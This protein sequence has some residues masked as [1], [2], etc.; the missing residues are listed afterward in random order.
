MSGTVAITGASGFV[1]RYLTTALQESGW[2]VK[3]LSRATTDY[4][5]DSLT[6]ALAGVDCVI[7]L[8]GRRMTREDA[9]ND[10]APFIDPNVLLTGRLM[11]A[12][13]ACG[14]TRF[15]FASTIAVYSPNDPTPYHEDTEP[16]PINA[17]ALSKV[18]AEDYLT[19]L[20]RTGGPS[21]IA[22]RLAAIYG[23]GEKGTPALMRFINQACA[24]ET[25]TLN[26]NANYGIDQLYVRD[27]VSAFI[28]A[29]APS[30]PPGAYNIGAGQ[31]YGIKTLAQ[32]VN[33]VFGNTDNLDAST[34][35]DGPHSTPYMT[36]TKAQTGLHWQPRF[37]LTAGLTDLRRTKEAD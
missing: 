15:V 37:D 36:I 30:T 18:M 20:K 9:P 4:S 23:H 24:G 7:H 1:G 28:A 27:A 10:L 6:M 17:Y 34:A 19:L 32:T 33:T 2:T 25:L 13:T 8:A 11:D 14:V 35:T 22:L 31:V 29:L 21:V 16:H 26:G 12:A 3:A 5:R